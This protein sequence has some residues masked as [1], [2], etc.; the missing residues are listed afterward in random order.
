MQDF[1]RHVYKKDINGIKF[2]YCG[3]ALSESEFYFED[4]EHS[5]DAPKHQ[6][7]VCTNCSIAIQR[8]EKEGER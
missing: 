4:V 7:A 5:K 1:E 2:S 3:E 8:I 6:V